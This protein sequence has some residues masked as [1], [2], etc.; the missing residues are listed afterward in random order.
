MCLEYFHRNKSNYLQYLLSKK[1]N[2]AWLQKG[3]LF[4]VSIMENDILTHF[5]WLTFNS[6]Y[7]NV[8]SGIV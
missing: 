8:T 1:G 4:N 7:Y 3:D 5:F 2:I 6:L